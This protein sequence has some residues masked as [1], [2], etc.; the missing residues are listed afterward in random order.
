MRACKLL[1]V[2]VCAGEVRRIHQKGIVVPQLN[3][4][5]LADYYLMVPGRYVFIL[6][7]TE[8]D[9]REDTMP[10]LWQRVQV[11]RHGYLHEK[12]GHEKYLDTDLDG[13]YCFM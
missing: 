3:Y 9:D 13:W 4:R 7:K 10:H 12:P 8:K 6:Y 1:T 5:T 2:F 11:Q